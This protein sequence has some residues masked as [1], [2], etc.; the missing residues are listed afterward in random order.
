MVKLDQIGTTT[1]WPMMGRTWRSA[2]E[3][4]FSW[5]R[6]ESGWGGRIPSWAIDPEQVSDIYVNPLSAPF[7]VTQFCCTVHR[8]SI[9]SVATSYLSDGG[10]IVRDASRGAP[11]VAVSGPGS[12]PP[13]PGRLC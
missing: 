3:S 13:P 1:R 7:Y 12:G 4:L 2:E 10:S 9:S 5:T 11:T 6:R 8:V